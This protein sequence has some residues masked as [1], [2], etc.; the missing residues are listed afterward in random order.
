MLTR[1]SPRPS[2]SPKPAPSTST[3]S[4]VGGSVRVAAVLGAL[5]I[6]STQAAPGFAAELHDTGPLRVEVRFTSS[7][8]EWR[9]SVD[10]LSGT[11]TVE[12]TQH[13]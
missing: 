1:I 5:V 3:Y 6:L 11:P 8:T 10:L 4:S 13:D 9:I 12:I 2:R 7:T